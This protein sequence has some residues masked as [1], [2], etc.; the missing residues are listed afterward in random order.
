MSKKPA[1]DRREFL[2]SAALATAGLASGCSIS[3]APNAAVRT[4]GAAN[5]QRTL[6]S[7]IYTRLLGVRPHLGAHE[8]ISR[9]GGGR[10]P[11]EV[12]AAMAEANDYF[13]DMYELNDAA[14]RRAAEL[15]GAEAAMITCGG[16][17]GLLLGA[18]ACLTGTDK[19][20]V[21]ALPHPTWPRCECLIQTA[22]RFDYD[23]AYRSAGAT[24]VEAKTRD[25]VVAHLGDRT[26][27][28]AGLSIA[29]RQGIFAPPF[30]VHRAPPPDPQLVKPEELIAVGNKAGVPVIIDM[31]SDLPPWTNVRRFLGAGA[32]LVVLS[33]GKSIGGPQATGILLG[34]RGLIEAARL[35]ASPNDNVGRG[36]KV[37]KEEIIGLIVALE[38]Y[39]KQDH[40]AEEE[41]WNARARRVVNRLQ[42]IPGLTAAY[43]LNTAGFGDADLRWDEREIALN[44]DSLRDQLSR[45][46]PRV[47]LEVIMTQDHGTTVW[48]AT[49]RTR[50]LRDG[51]ELLVARRLREVFL[52]ARGQTKG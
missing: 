41:R 42:G 36:M 28:I 39:V 6:G 29:E 5:T 20:K 38:R 22:Q 35:N 16:F 13:V 10:M 51:E 31:A 9:L 1:L 8:H 24:I 47:Q 21:E 4:A 46:S 34:R 25:D 37:G 50:V 3:E 12:L 7:N 49:A 23:R 40:L 14:G 19:A 48:H 52:A 17:S 33:G 45:G 2:T 11:P 27:M 15:L 43:A 32:D 26:A 18:A 44:R 30:E